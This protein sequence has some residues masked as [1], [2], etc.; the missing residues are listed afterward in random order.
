MERAGTL[1]TVRPSF[2]PLITPL[3]ALFLVIVTTAKDNDST[4][5]VEQAF[6]KISSEEL[7]NS[8]THSFGLGLSIA[9]FVV[10]LILAARYGTTWHIA[11]CVIYGS[12]PVCLYLASTLYHGVPLSRL[13][14]V[15]K[16]L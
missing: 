15:L 6:C 10:L 14:H 1:I 3:P 12:S 9:G 16:I 4:K 8:C 7:V 13:K 11:G 2:Q 5:S